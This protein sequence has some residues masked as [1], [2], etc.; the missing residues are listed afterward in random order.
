M[1]NKREKGQFFTTVSPFNHKLFYEWYELI[2]DKHAEIFIEPFAGSNN[3]I[4]MIRDLDVEQPKGWASY[5]IEPPENNVTPDVEVIQ[6]DTLND[7]PIGYKVSI[8]N[9][10]YLAKNSAKR[11][12]MPFPD[13]EFDDLYKVSLSV[14]LENL[15][16]VAAIIPESFITQDRF[17]GRLFGVISLNIKMFDDTEAPVC[18]AL[19]TPDLSKD[20]E[21]YRGD[22]Y[23]GKFSEISSELDLFKLSPNTHK[24]KWKF[25]DP[26]GKI[27]LRA[28]DNTYSDSIEFVRGETIDSSEI[29]VSSRALTRISGVS[30]DSEEDLDSFIEVC[31]RLLSTYRLNTQDIFMTSFKGL[32]ADGRYRRRLSFAEARVLL[33]KGY[34][35]WL[36]ESK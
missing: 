32:R 15:E 35:V 36:K 1:D 21:I 20:Y 29:K 9:P 4:R 13:T 14:M 6:Q 28:I 22:T 2:G 24:Q 18:L 3:I 23:I 16:Y 27:G 5:D 26:L 10:P 33:N 25:N 17:M 7:F 19:F 31:N 30:F 12:G 8:T 11:R 34:E